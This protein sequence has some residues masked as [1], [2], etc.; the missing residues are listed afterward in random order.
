MAE[1]NVQVV[2]SVRMVY[3]SEEP[4]LYSTTKDSHQGEVCVCEYI[5]YI[6]MLP[7]PKNLRLVR[8]LGEMPGCQMCWFYQ[9]VRGMIL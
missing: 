7:P 9:T 5:L 6:Y 4:F 8:C 1:L 3:T 2:K